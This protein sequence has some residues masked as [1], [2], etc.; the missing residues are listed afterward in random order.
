MLKKFH[1]LI[2]LAAGI[3]LLLVSCD[4]KDDDNTGDD[5]QTPVNHAPVASFTV[6]PTTGNTTTLFV[7][8]A[9]AS[10]DQ[11]DALS[12]LTLRWDFDNDGTWDTPVS[13]SP[14]ASHQY[15][16]AGDYTAKLE[17]TDSKG[18]SGTATK[19][20]TVIPVGT[21]LPPDPPS[22]PVPADGAIDQELIITLSWTCSDPDQDPLTYDVYFGTVNPPALAQ[23]DVAATSFDPGS[24]QES[25]NYFWKIVARDDEGLETAGPVWQFS[26]K[27]GS[28]FQCGDP[29]TDPRDGKVYNTIFINGPTVDQC[30][31]AS[32]M[33]IGTRINGSQAMADNGA[34]EKYCYDD[35]ET[36]CDTYG[37]L[38]Q[39][40][41]M[42]QYVTTEGAQGICPAGWHVASDLDWQYLE[43]AIGMPFSEITKTGMRGTDE[44]LHLKPG[45]ST[46]FNALFNGYRNNGGNFLNTGIYSTFATST[47][48]SI[49]LAYVRY[50]FNNNDQI[51]RDGNTEKAFGLGVRCIAD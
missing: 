24:L 51:Y 38:Y 39:W 27:A 11:E 32:N 44:A 37:A 45:G 19:N 20:I 31:M 33:N 2:L 1:H 9:S 49:N 4:K 13:G 34:I 17:V 28:T 48:N 12:S 22:N 5:N 35:N 23:Q 6:N 7:F 43:E 46:G 47:Q 3:S 40:N 14:L 25:T 16:T 36:N 41:E 30:W 50:L 15:T 18:L 29:F 26:T 8:D 21:N 42:M 10:T